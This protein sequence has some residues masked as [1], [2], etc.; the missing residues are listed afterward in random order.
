MTVLENPREVDNSESRPVDLMLL[1]LSVTYLDVLRGIGMEELV[2]M[3]L[4]KIPDTLSNANEPDVL[5]IDDVI[6]KLDGTDDEIV[7][8]SGDVAADN[9]IA[10][11]EGNDLLRADDKDEEKEEE[12]EDRGDSDD[13][14][15]E[16]VE[17]KDVN[18]NEANNRD[19]VDD[20]D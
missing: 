3:T 9:S 14:T 12:V 19:I 16:V 15:A 4:V 8:L 11:G 6:S 5:G 17:N 20:M 10:T 7:V 13:E 2:S 1:T 18:G